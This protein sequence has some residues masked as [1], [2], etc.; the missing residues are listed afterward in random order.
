MLKDRILHVINNMF[1]NTEYG[2]EAFVI[3]KND[4]TLKRL[5]LFEGNPSNLS[6]Q[7]SENFKEKVNTTIAEFIKEKYLADDAEYEPVEN[8]ADNQNKF[9][10]IEQTD[11]YRPFDILN[12]PINNL[13]TF[14]MTD[15]DN[16]LGLL[17][18]FRRGDNKIW[19]Y[20]HIYTVTIPNKLRKNWLSIQ[21]AETF[22]EMILPLFPIAKKVNLI[23]I[24]QEITTKDISL[25]QRQFGFETYIRNSAQTVIG[26]VSEIGL[27]ENI[28]KLSSYVERSKLTYAK[29]M[30]RIRHSAVLR[31]SSE[32]LLNKVQTLPR[33]S[34]KFVIENNRIVLKTY[35]HV[36]NLI[37]LLDERYTRSD[38]TGEEYSTDVKRLA[39]PI[40]QN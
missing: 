16:A 24:G 32:Q 23:I 30:M 28:E 31:M 7:A 33:W 21:Q 27:F 17:F 38:V 4:N 14:N 6:G 35:N 22:K 2:F 5:V 3:M 11:Q 9:Y 13:Q 37:D 40:E 18:M 20:Q 39:P 25:M 15:R 12:T 26:D 10:V 1:Q 34:G 36:E 8:I 19:G 29:K